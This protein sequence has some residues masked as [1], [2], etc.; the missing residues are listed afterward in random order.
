[1]RERLVERVE[2]VPDRLD[3][4]AIDDLI[5]QPEE[6]VLD[7]TPDLGQGMQS[8]PPQWCARQGDV[9]L[10]VE[11]SQ[12]APLELRLTG[13]ERLLEALSHGIER[14]AGL[15]VADVP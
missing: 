11:L 3:L 14:H 13:C 4:A 1:M 6:D 2:V 9:E 5:P 7:L 15:S 8:S 12:S 10:L